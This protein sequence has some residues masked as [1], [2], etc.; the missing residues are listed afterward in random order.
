MYSIVFS[1][2]A[3]FQELHN[4]I[5]SYDIITIWGHALPDGD[6]YGSQI[7]MKQLIQENYPEKEVYVFGSGNPVF[8]DRMGKMDELDMEKVS[9]SLGILVDVACL[10]RVEFQEV[11]QCAAWIKFDHH[12]PNPKTPF[13]HPCYVDTERVAAA[14]ILYDFAVENGLKMNKIFAE[15]VYLGMATDSGR[16]IYHGT[17]RHTFEIVAELYKMGA[18]FKYI[19]EVAYYEKPEIKGFKAF[20]KRHTKYDGN[21]DY[22]VI[23]YSDYARFGVTYEEGSSCVNAIAGRHGKPIYML[24]AEDKDG[25]YRIELRSNKLYPVHAV[26]VKFGGGG[27]TYASGCSIINGTPTVEEILQALNELQPNS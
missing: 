13:D 5:K 12:T 27:H 6:C 22:C 14:E 20:M 4:I 25:N 11:Q 2:M 19:L 15:A 21:V 24:A 1:F 23:H 10:S 8:F 7:A 26:A 16:F 9:K 17:M 3:T 18:D